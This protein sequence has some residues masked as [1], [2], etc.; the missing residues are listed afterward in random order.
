M[1]GRLGPHR[2][3]QRGDADD[4]HDALQVVGQQVQGHFGGNPFERLHLEVG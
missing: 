1:Q 2:C 4:V 3:D